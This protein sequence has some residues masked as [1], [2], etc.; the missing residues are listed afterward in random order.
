MLQ[1]EPTFTP[2]GPSTPGLGPF[3]FQGP[4][5]EHVSL[6]AA[7]T[8]AADSRLPWPRLLPCEDRVAAYMLRVLFT[9]LCSTLCFGT[10]P[11]VMHCKAC[12]CPQYSASH[13]CTCNLADAIA[14]PGIKHSPFCNLLCH[15]SLCRSQLRLC[16]WPATTGCN[17]TYGD[18]SIADQLQQQQCDFSPAVPVEMVT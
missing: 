8:S 11:A 16:L 7:H 18:M 9:I 6:G 4:I 3:I 14:V 10:A 5:K 2:A 17:H 12:R 13:S 1:A 15:V